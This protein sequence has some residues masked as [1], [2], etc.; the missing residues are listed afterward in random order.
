MSKEMI[1]GRFMVATI[2]IGLSAWGIHS[3]FPEMYPLTVIWIIVCYFH[4]IRWIIYGDET[5]QKEE[6]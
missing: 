3:L 6:K 2:L 5:N 1:G 4:A